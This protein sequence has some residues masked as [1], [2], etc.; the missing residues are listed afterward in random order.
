MAAVAQGT[1]TTDK[2]VF[3]VFFADGPAGC[4]ITTVSA[5]EVIQTKPKPST[6]QNLSSVDI[7]REFE[8]RDCA[9]IIAGGAWSQITLAS[10]VSDQPPTEFTVDQR[11]TQASLKMTIPIVFSETGVEASLVAN[12]IWD[13]VVGQLTPFRSHVTFPASSPGPVIIHV[14]GYSRPATS[15]GSLFDGTTD[16]AMNSVP[17]PFVRASV[18]VRTEHSAGPKPRLLH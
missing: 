5:T 9:T 14:S 7:A 17:T 12:V 10:G 16:Y 11:L 6:I 3:A 8:G 1:S 2:H 18:D 4:L 13:G 15:S